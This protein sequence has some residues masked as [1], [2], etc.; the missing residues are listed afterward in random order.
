MVVGKASPMA[1]CGVANFASLALLLRR[2][3]HAGFV[4]RVVACVA[5][6]FMRW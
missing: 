4:A 6:C 5:V 2:G 3:A 1:A